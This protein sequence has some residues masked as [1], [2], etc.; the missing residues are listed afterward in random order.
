MK[1]NALPQK[2]VNEIIKSLIIVYTNRFIIENDELSQ[3]RDTFILNYAEAMLGDKV[4]LLFILKS[5][6]RLINPFLI[7]I[8]KI[9]RFCPIEI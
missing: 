5:P 7:F 1:V 6:L 9:F 2:Y 4:I 3:L 8:D